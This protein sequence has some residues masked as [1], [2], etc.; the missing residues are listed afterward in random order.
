T[1]VSGNATGKVVPK[2]NT[3]ID[4][5]KSGISNR[6]LAAANVDGSKDNFIVKVTDSDEA[7]IAIE[8]ALTRAYGSLDNLKYFAM[9]ISLYDSTGTTKILNTAG[10]SVNVTIPIPDAMAQFAGNNKV[11]TV[12]AAGNMEK[13]N[14]RLI[15]IDNVPCV[16]FKAPHFS[17]YA[18]YVETN[19][20]TQNAGL[21]DASPKTG[22][23]IHP[24]WFLAIGLA[25]ASILMFAL[26]PSKKVVKVIS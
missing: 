13:V 24:K 26:R 7:R 5:T 14:A 15:T 3:K 1:S 12:D 16:S 25:L 20:L 2:S 10:L 11:M 22:D 19:N 6:N 9:D 23:P 21:A 17:P 18:L 8:Q 4:V